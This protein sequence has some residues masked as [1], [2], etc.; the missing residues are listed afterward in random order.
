[1]E[2]KQEF[3]VSNTLSNNDILEISKLTNSCFSSIDFTKNFPQVFAHQ[4]KSSKHF[5]LKMNNKLVGFCTLHP[6][7][8]PTKLGYLHAYCVGSVSIHPDFQGK[9][10]AVQL[11]SSVEE[12]SK[13][14]HIDFLFLFPSLEK[15]YLKTGYKKTNPVYVAVLNE[16]SLFSLQK[17]ILQD[18]QVITNHKNLSQLD[19]L[20][21]SK[22]WRFIVTH[23]FPQECVFSYLEFCLILQIPNMEVFLLKKENN[24]C[25][26]AFFNKG[27]DF[28]NVIHGAYYNENKDMLLLIKH[29]ML[30]KISQPLYFFPGKDEE[31]FKTNFC[32]S[33]LPNLMLKN[34]SHNISEVD[35]LSCFNN[36][37]EGCYVNSLQGC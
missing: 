27:D 9:G 3:V 26:V 14:N 32:F 31:S 10:L 25:A 22:I 37:M 23:A 8:F 20:L 7:F 36:P 13:E 1:M 35:L 29:V 17:V 16:S 12:F 33:P 6:F 21:K 15:L 34:L 2:K 28:K 4:Q 5:T 19:T 30:T 18:K 11:I 24:L